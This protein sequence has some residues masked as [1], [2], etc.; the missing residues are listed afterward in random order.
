M[1]ALLVRY[2]KLG[3][4]FLSPYLLTAAF[5]KSQHLWAETARDFLKIPVK[6]IEP[7]A[8]DYAYFG[9]ESHQGVLTP[10]EWWRNHTH[11]ILDGLSGVFYLFFVLFFIGIA[12]GFWRQ[13]GR[14]PQGEKKSILASASIGFLFL[15]IIGY[16]TYFV[17]PAAPPWYVEMKGLSEIDWTVPANP[18]GALAFDHLLGVGVFQGMYGLSADVFGAVPSLHVAYP[19]LALTLAIRT[20]MLIF[21]SILYFA[22]MVFSAVYLNHHYVFDALVG[23]F[24]GVFVG[25]ICDQ[26][27]IVSDFLFERQDAGFPK[28]L[29]K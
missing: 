29:V 9:I 24:Y 19:A 23:T 12:A 5:Y 15:N 8:F 25:Q 26:F 22:G 6:L 7:W 1:R 16:I 14:I 27:Y 3:L 28:V 17:Y 20:R 2:K 13:A 4:F 18:A 11:P 10:N 21:P